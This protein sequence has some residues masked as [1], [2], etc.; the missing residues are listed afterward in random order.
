M[1]NRKAHPG[2]F[3]STGVDDRRPHKYAEFE[4]KKHDASSVKKIV[5]SL[6]DRYAAV[7]SPLA[8]KRKS[9]CSNRAPSLKTMKTTAATSLLPLHPP[10]SISCRPATHSTSRKHSHSSTAPSARRHNAPP[11]AMPKGM[12]HM[13]AFACTET[14]VALPPTHVTKLRSKY[15]EPKRTGHRVDP[16]LTTSLRVESNTVADRMSG[17][18]ESQTPRMDLHK[19][20][21]VES[22]TLRTRQ[23]CHALETLSSDP[24]IK[25]SR[26]WKQLETLLKQKD[27]EL[28][29]LQTAGLMLKE[30]CVKQDD[31]IKTLKAAFPSTLR[32]VGELRNVCKK[33]EE[34]LA[35]SR[36]ALPV[37]QAQMKSL[38]EGSQDTV[39]SQIHEKEA[40]NCS[41]SCLSMEPSPATSAYS[42][43]LVQSRR[44]QNA[45][46]SCEDKLSPD[47][48]CKP[49]SVRYS[50][51]EQLLSAETST[52][53]KR[54][55]GLNA[56]PPAEHVMKGIGK[57]VSKQLRA[58]KGIGDSLQE[59]E[60]GSYEKEH[61]FHDR[62]I[63]A[64]T[65]SRSSSTR[66]SNLEPIKSILNCGSPHP[67]EGF[68][69]SQK[70]EVQPTKVSVWNLKPT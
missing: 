17:S 29:N 43:H 45:G 60:T 61:T 57:R 36:V 51:L 44:G 33:Q 47:R 15:A 23:T 24:N 18:M 27:N 56:V 40:S 54:K 70:Q 32:E 25:G 64:T 53:T 49:A 1:P 35:Q 5:Q 3:T 10:I 59:L 22:R 20:L 62:Y 67:L 8:C 11:R 16:P 69:V 42:E 55:M 21:L 12:V 50:R 6:S 38:K 13:Q 48:I 58:E 37:L 39:S 34:E 28:D 31:E 66:S 26:E 65:D 4:G 52:D 9:S 2:A 41:N 63:S 68:C 14:P 19:S 30:V 46:T 7:I